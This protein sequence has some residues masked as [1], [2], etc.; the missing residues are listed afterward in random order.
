MWLSAFSV[1]L[2]GTTSGAVYEVSV[3]EAD[4]KME[5]KKLTLGIL[6]YGIVSNIINFY[7]SCLFRKGQTP[8]GDHEVVVIVEQPRS[9]VAEEVTA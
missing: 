4:N 2:V 7:D 8:T 9:S 3:N 6:G 5:S 1:Y